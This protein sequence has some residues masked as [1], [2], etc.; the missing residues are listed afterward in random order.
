VSL[1]V[2]SGAPFECNCALVTMKE[3]RNLG[4]GNAT[5][6]NRTS[7]ILYHLSRRWQPSSC[8]SFDVY[9]KL[10][11]LLWAER[12][13][14]ERGGCIWACFHLM[15]PRQRRSVATPSFRNLAIAKRCAF[16]TRFDIFNRFLNRIHGR[17]VMAH[18]VLGRWGWFDVR[19]AHRPNWLT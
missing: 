10:L 19:V 13:S 9:Y 11:L 17:G 12:L 5:F 16:L 8:A 18:R 4:L 7:E 15:P 3:A 2:D 1:S 14:S 6:R